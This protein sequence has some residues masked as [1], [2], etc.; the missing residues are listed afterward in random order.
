MTLLEMLQ[1]FGLFLLCCAVVAII[2][3]GI[4]WMIYKAGKK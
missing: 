3:L 2:I 1:G 4:T